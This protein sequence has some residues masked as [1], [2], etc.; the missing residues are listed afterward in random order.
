M[1]ERLLGLPLKEHAKRKIDGLE[2]RIIRPDGSTM[3]ADEYASVRALQEN[4]LVG[5]VE[6]GI[7]KGEEDIT[8]INVTAV[9][10]PLEGYGVLITYSDITERKLAED[11]LV[12]L[13]SRQEAI[14]SAVPDIVMEVDHNKIY[15]WANPTGLDFFGDDVIG[16]EADDY[17]EGE[18]ETYRKVKPLFNGDESVIYVESWQRRKDGQQR[19]L[20]WWCRVLKDSSGKVTGALSTARDITEQKQAEKALIRVVQEWQT[21]FDANNDAIWIL[22][23]DQRVVR[24][25]KTAERYFQRPINQMIDK[26]CWEIVHGTDQPIHECPI[27]RTKMSLQ[28]ENMELKIGEGWF[29]ITVDPI[30]NEAGQFNGAV[31]IVS[32][33]TEQKLAVAALL[34]SEEKFKTLVE[35]SPLGISLIEQDGRYQYINPRFKDIFGY[36]IQ[37]IPTGA[38]WFKKAFP[39]KNDR[40]MAVRTWIEDQKQIGVGQARPRTYLVT[41]KDGSRKEILFMPVAME[42]QKQFVVYE[43]VTEKSIMEQQLAQAQ[44]MESVGRLAGGVAHDFN[45]MLGVILG[46][47]EL[48]MEQVDPASPLHADLEEIR[49]AAQRSAD[50][51]RQLLAFARR[52]TAVPKVLDLND[53]MTGMLK[54]LRRLIGEDIDLVWSPG[55]D[56][57]PVKMDPSQIDQILANLCVNA[58][59]AIAGVGKVTIETENVTLDDAYCADHPGFIP[60]DYVMLTVERQRVRH[61]HGD[62]GEPFRTVFHH[63]GS[64]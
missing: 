49:K 3:P 46:H 48:A 14:L 39:N 57:W 4:Q 15:T 24:S 53:T 35:K 27:I 21:T 19:L 34:E 31:H 12:A 44:K 59:D 1:S 50:L 41:C 63:Q 38:E 51:T 54:M 32:D 13:S 18:Q 7:V 36:T 40:D 22:D 28:R 45:N 60:G 43:D 33:I 30:L 61:G 2:W 26:Y 6:M 42:N 23:K 8:W 58:R 47:A 9:P 37:D 10:I 17:F 29:D 20:A 55:S 11:R 62:A 25:N 56:L 52:Q 16:R 5:N 64:R